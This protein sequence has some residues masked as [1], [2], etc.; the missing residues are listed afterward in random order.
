MIGSP[1]FIEAAV[2]RAADT[3]SLHLLVGWLAMLLGVLTGA[4]LGLFFHIDEWAGGY[5]SYRRRMLR[6]AHIAFFGLGFMNIFFGLTVERIALPP[7]NVQIASAGMILGL[8]AMPLV[9]YLSAWRKPL[10][11]LFP[12][13][14]LVITGAIIAVLLGW[15]RR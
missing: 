14:V 1:L 6:L 2:R 10:R 4:G 13:P 8:F 3:V 5:S 7:I 9:C 11:V 12:V 15:G